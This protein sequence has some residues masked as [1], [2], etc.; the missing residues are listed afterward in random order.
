MNGPATEK[1]KTELLEILAELEHEQ[2]KEWSMSLVDHEENLSK[3][4]VDR[5][6]KLWRPYNELTEQEK[7][8]DRVYAEK[9]LWAVKKHLGIK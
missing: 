5:W 1:R 8:Q 3:T 9:V 4:R 6:M 7:D 2:W